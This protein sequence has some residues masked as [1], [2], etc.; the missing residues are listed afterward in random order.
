VGRGEGRSDHAFDAHQYLANY[1]DLRAAFGTD[2]TA[3]ARHFIIWGAHEGRSDDAPDHQPPPPPP[4]PPPP[5]DLTI[6]G[7]P[8]DDGLRGTQGADTIDGGPG[9]DIIYGPGPDGPTPGSTVTRW[10]QDGP[11][12][13]YGG[14]S[15]DSF[16]GAAGNDTIDG[17][18]GNDTIKGSIGADVMTGSPGADI[19]QFGFFAPSLSKFGGD[20]GATTGGSDT[21]QDFHSGQDKIDLTG[22]TLGVINLAVTDTDDGALVTYDANFY[23]G[24]I[25]QEIAVHGSIGLSDFIIA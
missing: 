12:V 25:H 5:P 8:G 15:N 13:L 4:S 6:R 7:T 21:I 1:A 10:Q 2:E 11:D 23:T 18:P 22:F 24:P 3:A 19:F 16:Y 17:G 20:S 14:P 9:N